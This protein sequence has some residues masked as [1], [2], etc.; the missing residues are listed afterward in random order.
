MT[1]LAISAN[2]DQAPLPEMA[3]A[4]LRPGV[5]VTMMIHGYRYRPDDPRNDPHAEIL[6]ARPLRRTARIVSWPRRL[7]FGR[8]APGVAIGFGWDAGGTLWQAHDRAAGAG[9]A[10]AGLIAQV[11]AQG[12][13]PV[14]II[15]HSLGAR[16]ALSALHDLSPGD[17]GRII[18]LA[19]AEFRDVARAALLTPAG[20]TAEVLNVTSTE[21]A[22]FDIGF[23]VLM[24]GAQR[25][26][27]PAL[28]AGLALPNC[29]TLRIDDA[30]HRDGL[31]KMGFPVAGASRAV[32]HWSAYLRPGLFPLYR[33]FLHRPDD[34]ALGTL[35]AHLPARGATAPA[36]WPFSG[37]G[38]L[39]GGRTGGARG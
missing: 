20:R 28:G 36:A 1:V 29:V 11:R 6:A 24:A 32:C 7:G 3:R 10:L 31:R 27:G 33:A 39:F 38:G 18:L 30:A 16:V 13:G 8:G 26:A 9:R 34:L 5:P 37:P 21:N 2:R 23:R 17:A 15:A 12:A 19:G 25:A 22:L 35:R 14:N 4:M